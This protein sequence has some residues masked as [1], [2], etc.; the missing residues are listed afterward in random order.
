[1]YC[2]AFVPK[3]L[4][5]FPAH[6]GGAKRKNAAGHYERPPPPSIFSPHVYS[7]IGVNRTL[8]GRS[9]HVNEG[10]NE[11]VTESSC[12]RSMHAPVLHTTAVLPVRVVYV[13][14]SHLRVQYFFLFRIHTFLVLYHSSN[15]ISSVAGVSRGDGTYCTNGAV[16]CCLHR[17]DTAA[18]ILSQLQQS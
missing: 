7:S 12:F 18:V 15:S 8:R 1:M 10:M 4:C 13:V 3:L 6:S 9:W 17:K 16:H 2:C 11:C 5:P 14:A